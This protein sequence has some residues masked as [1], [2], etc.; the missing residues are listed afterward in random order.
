MRDFNI[1]IIILCA[2]FPIIGIILFFIKTN[3]EPEA[4]QV[5]LA[6]SISSIIISL[7]FIF[8]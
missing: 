5:Y 7:L 8:E 4:A 3:D 1:F 6:T 2:L